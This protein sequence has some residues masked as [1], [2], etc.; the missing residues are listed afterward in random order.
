MSHPQQRQF[1][2]SLS[3]SLSSDFIDNKILE[4]GSYSV[5]GSIREFFKN[6]TYSGVDLTEGPC[7][8]I[9]CEGDKLDHPDDFYDIAISCECFEHNPN[10]AETFQNMWRMTKKGGVVIFTCATTGRAEHGTTRTSVADSPGT[11]LM[12]WDYYRNLTE[13]DFQEKFNLNEL[14]SS[15]FFYVNDNSCDLYFY[16]VKNGENNIFNAETD[17]VKSNAIHYQIKLQDEI[18][19]RKKREKFVPR[20]LRP[21][22]RVLFSSAQRIEAK[23]GLVSEY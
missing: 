20:P 19:N 1:I 17:Q 7:V 3:E 9:I 8:D 6:S 13:I 15:S 10:W 11:Q 2:K 21:L 22:F 23:R 12:K 16:G 18:I 4:I 5:N 14:F